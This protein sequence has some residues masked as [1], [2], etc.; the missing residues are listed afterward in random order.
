[1]IQPVSQIARR[2]GDIAWQPVVERG[3]AG[4]AMVVQPLDQMMRAFP[5]GRALVLLRNLAAW[6]VFAPVDEPHLAAFRLDDARLAHTVDCRVLC[7]R[8][9]IGLTKFA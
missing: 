9:Y 5:N 2:L 4:F 7:P 1:M 6:V 3:R 8:Q